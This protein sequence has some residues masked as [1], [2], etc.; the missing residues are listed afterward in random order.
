MTATTLRLS[1]R[2]SP[3]QARSAA[4]IRSL[5]VAV[6][7][8]LTRDGLSRCTTTRIAERAGTSV[9]S[10]YQYYP[11][12][13]ALLADVLRCHLVELAEAIED[14]C[15]RL[16]G[17]PVS[18]MASNLTKTFL[19]VKLSDPEQ[20][21]ALYAIA[22]ERGAAEL[23]KLISAR[24]VEAI[25]VMLLTAPHVHFEQPA[26]VATLALSAVVGAVRAVL[27]GHAAPNFEAAVEGE[28]TLI[29]TAYLQ[30]FA[31]KSEADDTDL[32]AIGELT[33]KGI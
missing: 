10:I 13:D 1:P 9:G 11:N 24:M 4:T 31:L 2:K 18:E 17:Q 33:P 32:S 23:V 16:S 7:Q 14:V 27:E 21:K 26:I 29:L 20:S 28:V 15:E 22:G 5:H 8:V 3:V 25:A 30:S 19:A 12:R 6:V